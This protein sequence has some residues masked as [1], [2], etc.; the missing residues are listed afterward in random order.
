MVPFLFVGL[1][2]F[3]FS[4]VIQAEIIYSRYI[5]IY[6]I[7]WLVDSVQYIEIVNIIIV[8]YTNYVLYMIDITPYIH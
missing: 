8:Y 4:E 3:Y 5:V 1:S 7:S 6:I 2:L